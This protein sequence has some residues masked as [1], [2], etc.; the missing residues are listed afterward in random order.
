LPDENLSH[1]LKL[2]H[3]HGNDARQNADSLRKVK[4]H[5]RSPF[6]IN[7]HLLYTC[8]EKNA[9][10]KPAESQFFGFGR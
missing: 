1:I 9:T 7:F 4:F 10:K 6:S 3:D 2:H 5:W 8:G